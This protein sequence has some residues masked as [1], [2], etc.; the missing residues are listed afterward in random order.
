[1]SQKW[2]NYFCSDWRLIYR[3]KSSLEKKEGKWLEKKKNATWSVKILEKFFI[4]Q[5]IELFL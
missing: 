2:F 1:M 3:L 5:A 4:L